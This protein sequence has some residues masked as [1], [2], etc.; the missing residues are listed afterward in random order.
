M[1]QSAP[2][3][4]SPHVP[5]MVNAHSHAF[6]RAM[7]GLAEKQEDPED[8]FWTWREL[9][10]RFA[11]QIGPDDLQAI[12]AQLYVELLKSGY[13]TVCEFHYL[14]HQPD[15]RPYDNPAEMSLALVRAAAEAGIRLVLLPT[16]YM[17]RGF[18]GGPLGDRQ[19]RF[20][21]GLDEYL[22]L[23]ATL[24]RTSGVQVGMALHSL[25]AVPPEAMQSLWESGLT[26]SGPIHIHIA[27]QTAEVD[28]CLQRRGARPVAWLL[29]HAPVDSRWTLVHATHLSG[30]EIGRLARSGANVAICPSTEANLG[31]GLFPLPEY[32]AQ[33]GA[34]SIGTDSHVSTSVVEEL[35]WLEYGQRLTR[36]R[37]NIAA[38]AVSPHVGARLYRA[39]AAGGQLAA[40][41]S[42]D[43][44]VVRVDVEAVE[45]IGASPEQ[46]LDA[47][48]FAGN[49][50]LVRDVQMGGRQVILEGRHADEARIASRY[51]SVL[52]RLCA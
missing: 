5:A 48:V 15:G 29:D 30:D 19:R 44:D 3:L 52:K 27:E 31:D 41:K 10:Y 49:R 12:A 16:L 36:R 51:R 18:D 1:I 32:L 37:R 14:H 7:A 9:M 13:T 38:D 4:G 24:R 47:C 50:N 2:L 26:G 34:F 17:T 6:Q 46:W 33:G 42:L 11:G 40:G 43:G 22:E 45:L 35:R 28:E 21:H 39:A 23:V 20:G 25:R 8:S